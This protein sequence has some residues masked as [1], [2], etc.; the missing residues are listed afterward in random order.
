MNKTNVEKL[1]GLATIIFEALDEDESVFDNFDSPH[2][3][4]EIHKDYLD[5]NEWAWFCAKVRASYAGIDSEPQYL[6]CCSYENEEDFKSDSYYDSLVD[7]ALAD[8]ATKI[9]QAREDFKVL[10]QM[11]TIV[12]DQWVCT[13][14]ANY[15]NGGELP[16]DP[17]VVELLELTF[18]RYAEENIQFNIVDT[19]ES[20]FFS[21]SEC[22]CCSSSLGGSR[23]KA[24]YLDYSR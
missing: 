20:D 3:A 15:I 13:D 22:D 2:Q 6:G 12:D 19:G 8:L 23:Y 5:G 10:D 18:Q 11:P 16:E 24:V 7:E 14:C 17:E 21:S 9:D 4:K 1:R